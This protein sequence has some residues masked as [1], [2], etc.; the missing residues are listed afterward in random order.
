M[1]FKQLETVETCIVSAT[2]ML[3]VGTSSVV[4][5]GTFMMSGIVELE[6]EFM[7]AT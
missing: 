4:L 3:L 6:A 5:S 7:S 2:I 1:S